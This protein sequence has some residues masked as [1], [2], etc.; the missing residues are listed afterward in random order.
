MS[1]L[2]RLEAVGV[3]IG[4][5]GGVIGAISALLTIP[6]TGREVWETYFGQ[7]N[8]EVLKTGPLHIVYN[9]TNKLIVFS[10]GLTF[11]NNGYTAERVVI[12]EI[13]FGMPLDARRQVRLDDNE[14]ICKKGDNELPRVIQINKGD[15]E[16]I[17]CEARALLPEVERLFKQH[18]TQKVFATEFRGKEGNKYAANMRLLIVVAIFLCLAPHQR[19][20]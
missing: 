6:T 9:P 18:D 20:L 5:V 17:N 10:C 19:I 1:N 4:A 14:A 12:T 8:T 16:S 2:S 7:P 11:N 15:S 3:I 13:L